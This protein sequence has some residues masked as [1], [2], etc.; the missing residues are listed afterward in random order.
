MLKQLLIFSFG[1]GLMACS[2]VSILVRSD[3]QFVLNEDLKPNRID[4]LIAPYS[5]SVDLEM[6]EIIASADVDFL[7]KRK[8]SGN[9][10][11]W[12]ADAVFVNQTKTVKLSESIICLLNTGGIRSTINKGQITIG[13]LYKVMPFDNEIV[14]VHMPIESL[15]EI[16]TYLLQKG[17]EPISNAI[18]NGQSLQLNGDQKGD[19]HFWV[20]TSDYLYNGGDN[21]K[22]F[23]K[24]KDVNFTN[25]LLRD[26]LIEEAKIQKVLLSDTLNRMQF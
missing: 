8:P 7:I 6:G 15:K 22:F 20:I 26:A 5:D 12:V 4:S 17:G 11:N 18:M 3:T 10:C 21:M 24:G 23:T 14:W 16:E 1:A 2:S 25:K 19:T 9:L 13:D